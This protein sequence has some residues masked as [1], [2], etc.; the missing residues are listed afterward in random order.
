MIEYLIRLDTQFFLFLNSFN[1]PFWD[2]VMWQVSGTYIWL[3]LYTFIIFFIF[4]ELKWKGLITFFS[5]ILLILLADQGSVH[6]FKNI[7]QRLRPCHEPG[8]S[9]LVHLVNGKCGGKYGFVSS[10]AANTFAF[11]MFVVL[12]FRR[13]WPA[14]FIFFWAALV[15]YSRIYLGVHYP[16]DILGGALWGICSAI[17][18]YKVHQMIVNKFVGRAATST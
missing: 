2:V 1:N 4:R 18:L 7:F 8:I 5:L 13:K 3:P 17:I 11:A 6:L 9:E 14:F 16:F 10:H 15:S 12:L